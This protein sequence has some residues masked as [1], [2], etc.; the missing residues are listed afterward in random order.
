MPGL[1]FARLLLSL[2]TKNS[3][4]VHEDILTLK[5]ILIK[6]YIQNNRI[7]ETIKQNEMPSNIKIGFLL[8]ILLSVLLWLPHAIC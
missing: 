1:P 7:H 8:G 2:L 4:F 6:T 3:C 5:Y